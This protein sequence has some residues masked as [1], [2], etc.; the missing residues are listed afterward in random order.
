MERTTKAKKTNK[1]RKEV[2]NYGEY[3][4]ERV[5]ELHGIKD[6]CALDYDRD[7]ER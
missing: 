3:S 5:L 1:N 6:T 4:Y 7:N 2:R